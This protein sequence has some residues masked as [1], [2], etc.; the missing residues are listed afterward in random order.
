MNPLWPGEQWE[1]A[2]PQQAGMDVKVL[3]ALR[4]LVGGRGCVV[5][6]GTMVYTWGD[7]S[8][9]GDVASAAKPWYSHFLLTA[10][11]EGRIGALDAPIH[12]LVPGLADIN[13]DLGHKDRAIAWRHLATQTSCYGVSEKPGTA[14]DYN[15]WQMALFWDALFRGVYGATY[16]SV[17]EAILHPLLTDPLQCQDNPTFMA[18]GTGERPG[19]L[20]VSVRD[21]A[22]FGLLYLREGTWNGKQLLDP[23]LARMAVQS[24][25]PNSI[26]RTAGAQAQMVPGQRSNGS[27]AIPDNQCDHLGS[28]SWLW[29]TNGVDREGRRHWPDVPADAYGAFGHG[30]PRAMVVI[31]SLDVIVSWNDA[32]VKDRETE[33]RALKLLVQAVNDRGAAAPWKPRTRVSIADGKWRINGEPTYP[34]APAEGLLMNVRMVNCVFEDLKRPEFD[35]EL[36]TD[37][38]ISKVPE[39][40]AHGVRAFS[41]NLQGGFP[42][43]EGAVNS[44]FAP[45]GS[46]R[47]SYMARVR[48]VLEACDRAGVAVILGLYY[49]RQD[50]ILKDEAAVRAGV[51][52]TVNWIR[53]GGFANVVV[54]IANEATHPGFDHGLLRTMEGQGELISLAK[55]TWPELLVSTSGIGEKNSPGDVSGR[56]DFYLLHFNNTP[57]EPIRKRVASL[58][59]TDKPI[60]CNEDTKEGEEGAEVARMCVAEGVSWGMMLLEHNQ[61]YPFA[62]EGAADDPIVYAELR[63]LARR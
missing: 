57:L 1:T 38:F 26:P 28:Y 12:P 47:D 13:A 23:A 60:L 44:A 17:D 62:F 41:V 18:F 24:P 19:R 2:S 59:P 35:P 42:G 31:P 46:L 21:F 10:L 56:A 58:R 55:D 4:D 6:H 39:Y 37:E 52:N 40:A 63:R 33:G 20:A 7:Q 29:W 25:L 48:R 11:D 32:D 43:Y 3:D 9:R 15:D 49:Q 14:Y 51:V 53:D 16:D 8:A 30:G 61:Q 5:R 45:D 54:E 36:N 34:G 50:Q 22:R 27:R